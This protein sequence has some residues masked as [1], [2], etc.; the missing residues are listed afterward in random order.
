MASSIT[1]GG[2]A[3]G[4]DTNSIVDQLVK[5]ESK[6][7]DNA[8]AQ[9]AAF[10][11]Q[12]SAVGDLIT[13]LQSMDTAVSALGDTGVLGVKQVGSASGFTATP[14]SAATAGRYAI[15]VDTLAQA[16]KARSTSFAASTDPVTGGTLRLTMKGTNYDVAI[17]D[18]DSLDTVARSIN[19]SGAPVS[20]SILQANG[21]SYLSITA[22]DTG[23]TVGGPASDALT[24]TETSTGLLGKP[25]GATV[26]QAA[27]NATF[28]IDGLAFE[29]SSNTVSDALPGT[30]L[31][32]AK[33]T[34]APE[35]LVLAN[36]PDA[37][38][39]SLQKFVDAYNAVAKIVH[40][41]LNIA[42]M[43]D[44]TKTLSGDASVRA[45]QS[46]LTSLVTSQANPTSS[47]RALADLGVKTG[48]DG[49]LS[50]D[51]ARLASAI[52][53]DPSAV[54]ALFQKATTGLSAST[55]A[56]VKGYTNSID[57]VLVG[58]KKGLEQS[59]KRMDSVIAQQQLRVDKFKANLVKQFTAMEKVVSS[60][61]SIG[62]FLS[63]QEAQTA[64]SNG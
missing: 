45:L 27:T 10:N 32:L 43:T 50:I 16:A 38:K 7:V 44:R 25:L 29:R 48:S 46:A 36:D 28:S 56:L 59:A 30:T 9:Q 11:S 39:A 8:T 26:F 64:K 21:T 51:S 14:S 57:G 31:T 53:T 23:F 12:V 61:K 62:N 19:A 2:L 41:N 52:G 54:N 55:S 49:T 37:T 3:S 63:Q 20:A 6:S 22:R 35:D 4:L 24:I 5:I 17:G 18:G 60:F 47:V 33:Q 42:M 34:T 1:F 40:G 58:R 13:K 15:Q